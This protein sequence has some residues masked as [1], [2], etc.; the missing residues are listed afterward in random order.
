MHV[1]CSKFFV[2]FKQISKCDTC[3]YIHF[4]GLFKNIILRS[5]AV[6]TKK[7]WAILD[8]FT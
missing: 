6:V 3:L 5:L 7:I 1:Q 4:Q 8:F 2:C